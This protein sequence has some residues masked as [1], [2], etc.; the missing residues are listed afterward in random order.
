MPYFRAWAVRASPH[1]TDDE[2]RP[3]NAPNFRESG[4]L[5]NVWLTLTTRGCH[6]AVM[7]RIETPAHAELFTRLTEVRS[8]A[9]EHYKMAQ[10]LARER[11]AIIEELLAEGFNQSDL[12]RE[13]GVTRQAIQKMV[14][15]GQSDRQSGPS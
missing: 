11:R 5:D 10:S 13:L 6:T 9:I 1:A 15:V 8:A 12:A 2:R 7:K 14:A 4:P 3:R